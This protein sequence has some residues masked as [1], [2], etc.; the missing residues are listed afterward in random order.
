M[1]KGLQRH[2]SGNPDSAIVLEVQS[3]PKLRTL[4]GIKK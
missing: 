1:R 4:F 3:N 2:E